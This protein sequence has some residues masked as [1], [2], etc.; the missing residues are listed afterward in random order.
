ML[1]AVC[2]ALVIVAGVAAALL[3][4]FGEEEATTTTA[5][6]PGPVVTSPY[7]FT[8]ATT[9]TLDFGAFGDAKFLSL[10]L[11]TPEGYRSYLLKRD[12][13][14]FATLVVAL[15]R[16]HE[17]PAPESGPLGA[18]GGSAATSLPAEGTT[19]ELTPALTVVM[20]DRT[21]YR[22]LVDQQH[23]LLVR[24]DRAWKTEEDLRT[25]LDHATQ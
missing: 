20:P 4:R 6:A 8:E 14:Q 16:A 15:A 23:G 21:T 2:G 13:E 9:G 12:T 18:A 1:A 22:F 7:D 10:T 17:G 24:G 5:S 11:E 25:L 3:I 19:G